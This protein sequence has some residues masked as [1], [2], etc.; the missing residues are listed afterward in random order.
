MN[1]SFYELVKTMRKLQRQ[2]SVTK[3]N[4]D[5]INARIIE[6][7]VDAIIRLIESRNLKN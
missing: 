5:Y 3:L 7:E 1:Q 6:V 4:S 2:H